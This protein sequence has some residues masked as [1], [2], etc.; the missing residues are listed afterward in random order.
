M[1]TQ[2]SGVV[3]T[4]REDRDEF[5]LLGFIALI[6]VLVVLDTRGLLPRTRQVPLIIASM[7]VIFLAM[8]VFMKFFGDQIRERTGWEPGGSGILDE[9]EEGGSVDETEHLFDLNPKKVIK[10]FAWLLVYLAGLVFVGFWTT[11]IVFPLVYIMKYE[12]SPLPRRF[13]YYLLCTGV[14]VGT[15]W[16]LFVELLNVQSIWRLGFLP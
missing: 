13:V 15:L 16:I 8:T 2:L 11:N 4:V 9:I 14:I 7:M 5:L 10:H 3:R 1:S 6:V 12:T